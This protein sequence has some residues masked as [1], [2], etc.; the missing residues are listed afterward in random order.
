[1]P[2]FKGLLNQ[3]QGV[4]NQPY[5]GYSGP[6]QAGFNDDQLN[7]FDMVRDQASQ[8]S[9]TQGMANNYLQGTIQGQGANPYLGQTVGHNPY[10]G[11][12]QYLDQ[13]IRDASD[14]VTATYT[15]STLPS[16][17]SQFN[18]SGAYGGSAMQQ[19]VQGSQRELAGQLGK[20]STGLR[21]ADYDRQ[22]G[23][24][25]NALNRQQT[26][27]ARNAGLYGQ[28]QSN[29][30]QAVG[31][32]P[33]L[34]QMGYKDATALQTI[35]GQQQDLYQRAINDDREQ[36]TEAR[37]WDKNNLGLLSQALGTIRGGS[38]SSAATGANPNYKSAAENGAAY[39]ALLASIWN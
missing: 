12:N 39:A 36:F 29:R 26:D 24:A 8:N 5:Q 35:G 27:I 11:K 34:Q 22:V 16:Y 28:E 13:M 19:A 38:S 30:L 14:D 23:I 2:Y 3:T 25:E 31:M 4:M 33:Q 9:A 20:V 17:L 21:N 6:T 32:L 10:G 7:S 1:V 37:D 18:A 15:D